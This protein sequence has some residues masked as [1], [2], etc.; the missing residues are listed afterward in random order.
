M[1]ADELDDYLER[2]RLE[3]A[4]T[5]VP[6]GFTDRVMRAVRV[7]PSAL[8]PPDLLPTTLT[9]GALIVAG[10]VLLSASP[11]NMI[12]AGVLFALGLLWSWLDDPFAADF[13]IRLTPW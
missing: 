8:P 1:A 5:V 10:A 7:Q 3:S 9:S 4:A 2:A 11:E 6:D 13:N 12:A